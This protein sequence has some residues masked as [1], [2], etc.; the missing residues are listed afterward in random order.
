MLSQL[1]HV[2]SHGNKSPTPNN[3]G[4][5]R[6][7]EAITATI[8]EI[9]IPQENMWKVHYAWYFFHFANVSGSLIFWSYNEFVQIHNTY[10]NADAEIN[11]F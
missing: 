5:S 7:D 10:W 3:S 6:I 2:I 11:I 8:R 1:I 4:T 9:G